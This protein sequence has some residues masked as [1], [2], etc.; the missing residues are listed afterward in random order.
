MQPTRHLPVHYLQL[1]RS[2]SVAALVA[3]SPTFVAAQAASGHESPEDA[4]DVIRVWPDSPPGSEV[5]GEPEQVIPAPMGRPGRW[6]RNVEVP[7]LTAFLPDPSVAVGS[8]AIIAPGG[9]NLFLSIDHEGY[10][11]ARWLRS[12][13]VAAFV[14]RYRVRPTPRSDEAFLGEV[15]RLMRQPRESFS[16]WEPAI[17]DGRQA[18]RTVRAHA[19]RWGVDPDRIGIVGFS[20]GALMANAVAVDHDDASRPSF[21]ASIYGGLVG[22]IAVPEGAP[23]LFLAFAVDDPVM[24]DRIV[25]LFEAWR[26]ADAPVELHAYEAGG[27]GFGMAETGERSDSWVEALSGW[28]SHHGMLTPVTSESDNRDLP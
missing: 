22:P 23:P 25:P 8:A 11:V 3:V 26:D 20:A 1:A 28:L 21:V 18:I 4:T 7:S 19:D 24:R 13:G 16:N 15:M 9:G 6:V 10:E 14:L 5:T 12:R 17:E 27:H 2:A